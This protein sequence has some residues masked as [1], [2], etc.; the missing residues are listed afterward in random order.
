MNGTLSFWFLPPQTL[1]IEG[2]EYHNSSEELFT[3]AKHC[4]MVSTFDFGFKISTNMTKPGRFFI[5]W[6]H[7]SLCVYKSSVDI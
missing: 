7:A 2:G 3:L 4:G 1:M 6:I 5:F